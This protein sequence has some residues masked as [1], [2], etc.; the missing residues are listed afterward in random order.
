MLSVSKVENVW[1]HGMKAK[2]AP[3]HRVGPKPTSCY[4]KQVIY[5]KCII[6]S[7]QGTKYLGERGLVHGARNSCKGREPRPVSVHHRIAGAQGQEAGPPT[8]GLIQ[9]G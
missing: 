5:F 1:L 6:G 2:E 4:R 8:T 9:V 3:Q 7:K